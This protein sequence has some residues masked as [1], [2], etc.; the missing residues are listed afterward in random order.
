MRKII[1][2][3]LLVL[4]AVL[5]TG[6][7]STDARTNSVSLGS[8]FNGGDSSIKISFAEEAPPAKIRD[9]GLQ[10]FSVRVLVENEG[11]YDVADNE[12][13]ITLTGF[14]PQTIGLSDNSKSIFALRGFKK[15]GSNTIPGGKQQVVFDNL[16]YVDSVVSGTVP[17]TLYANICYPYQTKA[18]AVV[19]INGNTV[20][21]LDDKSKICEIEGNKDFANS[22]GPIQIANVKQY[23]LGQSS[24]QIQ[25][26]IVHKPTSKD[27]N[28]YEPNSIDSDCKIN[29]AS[30]SSSEALFKR[31]KVQ[32]TVNTG[33]TG[34]DC[35]STGKGTNT[36]T[37]AS[38]KYTVTCIQ[39]T[40]GEEEYPKPIQITLDYDYIDRISKVINIEH[41]QK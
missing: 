40:F 38:D 33:L 9:Q 31:D 27:G 32:Y 34:L 36:V 10:P 25:F 5:L 6:C 17:L 20:P 21:A 23:P 11:E 16:K 7:T 4:S 18:T 12:A 14:D 19:C 28:V 8:S 41:I 3:F 22:G 13:F 15:Q 39:D 35:E 37:L 24:I 30:P 29:G 1:L 26:D 2:L